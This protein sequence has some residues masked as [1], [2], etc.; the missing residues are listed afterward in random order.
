MTRLIPGTIVQSN[1]YGPFKVVSD[2]GSRAVCVEFIKTGYR[3][4]IARQKARNGGVKDRLSPVICGVGFIGE[5]ERYKLKTYRTWF[6]MLA[7]C[8]DA[9]TQRRNPSYIGCTVVPEWHNYQNFA[10]WYEENYE[11][12]L[13]LDKD[14]RIPGN[15][16][17]GPDTCMFVTQAENSIEAN[18]KHFVFLSPLGVRHYIYNL[19]EFSRKKGLHKGHMSSVH[20]G[21]LAH[22][23]GWTKYQRSNQGE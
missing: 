11:P 17:Y 1:N 12:G 22:H 14:I 5:G 7:R 10:L 20:G 21:V 15:R 6:F 19:S 18:A 3:T 2:N 4:V 16:V 13:Q 23:K 9:E 8:Y